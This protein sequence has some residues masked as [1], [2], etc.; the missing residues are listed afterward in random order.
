[1]G[2]IPTK[3]GYRNPEKKVER[4]IQ[5][6]ANRERGW[7]RGESE[8]DRYTARQPYTRVNR[9]GKN[10]RGDIDEER[11]TGTQ[12]QKDRDPEPKAKGRK[13]ESTQ[14][15]KRKERQ[16]LEKEVENDRKKEWWWWWWW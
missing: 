11:V 15:Q 4:S 3:E 10:L 2:R 12:R 8:R 5:E 14:R 16:G 9:E 6:I 7:S 1:M 13:P